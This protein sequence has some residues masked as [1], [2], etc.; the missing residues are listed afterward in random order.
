METAWLQLFW[1]SSNQTSTSVK[2]IRTN[3]KLNKCGNAKCERETKSMQTL[4]KR[5][6]M[7]WCFCLLSCALVWCCPFS[8]SLAAFGLEFACGQTWGPWRHKCTFTIHFEGR[9]Y[10]KFPFEGHFTSRA[11]LIWLWVWVVL[12]YLLLCTFIDLHIFCLTTTSLTNRVGACAIVAQSLCTC[13]ASVL[14]LLNLSDVSMLARQFHTCWL[15]LK[16]HPGAYGT[17]GNIY[18]H[19]VYSYANVNEMRYM[20]VYFV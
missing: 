9:I 4:S 3:T 7:R 14:V 13:W 16:P 5:E 19:V 18:S 20:Y 6:T 10:S 17:D 1:K 11:E 8:C 12:L 15:H 2:E